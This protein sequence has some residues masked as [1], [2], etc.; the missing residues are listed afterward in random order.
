MQIQDR[1]SF[2]LFLL[3]FWV[4]Y[5]LSS[6]PVLLLHVTIYIFCSLHQGDAH[7][8]LQ[9]NWTAKTAW[10]LCTFMLNF[11]DNIN[12]RSFVR[13][14][15]GTLM[16]K[17]HLE[18]NTGTGLLFYPFSYNFLI[19]IFAYLFQNFEFV[20]CHFLCLFR[21][22]LFIHSNHK[23]RISLGDVRFVAVPLVRQS[24]SNAKE[25]GKQRAI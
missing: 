7:L 23:Y 12:N 21:H 18:I 16:R 6:L 24:V 14:F 10:K 15:S 8:F 3:C 20:T 11:S 1:I 13:F 22:L 25:G 5:R 17:R 2:I 4:W 19:Q 9:L